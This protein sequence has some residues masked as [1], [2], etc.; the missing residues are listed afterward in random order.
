MGCGFFLDTSFTFKV[1]ISVI[2]SQILLAI[3]FG[4]SKNKSLKKVL[5][6][7]VLILSIFLL[8]VSVYIAYENHKL[9]SIDENTKISVPYNL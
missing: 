6:V 1:A 3:A 4:L 7:L 8:F 2:V 5:S 9:A